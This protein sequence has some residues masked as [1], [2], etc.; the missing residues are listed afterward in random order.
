MHILMT[1]NT[2]QNDVLVFDQHLFAIFFA[3]GI[4]EFIGSLLVLFSYRSALLAN[5]NQGI[6]SSIL[7]C[8]S[9]IATVA[10]YVIYRE[11]LYRI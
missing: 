10:S 6:C 8:S 7:C 1:G 5:I 4:C 9:I 3:G 11:R 2:E